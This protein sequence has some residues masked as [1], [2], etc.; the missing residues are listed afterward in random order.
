M[1]SLFYSKLYFIP[2]KGS[3]SLDK[4]SSILSNSWLKFA[5]NAADNQE[6]IDK[7][8][9]MIPLSKIRCVVAISP[10]ITKAY[11]WLLHIS[12]FFPAVRD[13]FRLALNKKVFRLM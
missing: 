4:V 2:E 1:S 5:A 11:G 3:L 7:I 8:K 10:N 9:I 6:Q 13:S 12:A